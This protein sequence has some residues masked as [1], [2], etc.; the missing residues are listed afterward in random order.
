MISKYEIGHPCKLGTVLG[1]LIGESGLG[2]WGFINGIEAYS[3]PK[4]ATPH[5]SV[6]TTGIAHLQDLTAEE[7]TQLRVYE[8]DAKQKSVLYNDYARAG[9]TQMKSGPATF[10]GSVSSP[11]QRLKLLLQCPWVA[12]EGQ[13]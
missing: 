7:L 6:L 5:G 3:V 13:T 9:A 11:A 12:Q 8:E 1:R 2:S 10:D 4:F